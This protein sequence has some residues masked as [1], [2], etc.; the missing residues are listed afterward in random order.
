MSQG[1]TMKEIILKL[2]GMVCNGCENRVQNV[3]KTIKGVK[4]VEANYKEGTVTILTKVDIDE[5]ILKEKI[6]N[7]GFKVV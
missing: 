2:E 5:K 6:E 1:D 3:I 7:I 4:K